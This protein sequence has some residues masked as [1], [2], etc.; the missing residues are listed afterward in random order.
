MDRV[1]R[2]PVIRAGFGVRHGRA[3][4][5]TA[6]GAWLGSALAVFPGF[7]LRG[8][9][10]VIAFLPRTAA[11]RCTRP[12]AAPA[13]CP[14]SSSA[15]SSARS[16]VLPSSGR[17]S[18]GGSSARRLVT[19]W[20]A[21]AGFML[22]GSCSSLLRPDPER[23]AEQ[24][25]PLTRA[26]HARRPA[27]RDPPSPRRRSRPPRRARELR[28]HG[29][30]HEPDRLRRVDSTTTQSD[31]FTIIGAHIVGMYA[32]VLVVGDLIDRIGRRRRSSAA[33]C[34]WRLP[35]SPSSGWRA[36][37][38]G[39]RSSASASAGT[40]P[41]WPRR[42]ARRPDRPDERGR[43]LGFSDLLSGMTGAALAL[44]GGVALKALGVAAS[45]SERPCSRSCPASGSSPRRPP[46]P[47]LLPSPTV[48]ADSVRL[49]T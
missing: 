29:R 27:L 40:S 45:R 24:F 20:L 11:P 21:G 42:R 39:P 49:F 43:L 18:P 14:S 37:H 41:S 38:G 6:L 47:L 3:R 44:L 28:R 9:A 16:S 31:V 7:A 8:A 15:P 22:A 23:I 2:M 30:R 4:R 26:R 36:S 33:S 17:C 12:R 10:S 25:A 13:A 19:P 5:L 1:G 48:E 35:A 34:S 32:L 46:A